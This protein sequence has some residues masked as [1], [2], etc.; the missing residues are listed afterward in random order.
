MMH[1]NS[2]GGDKGLFGISFLHS[3]LSA[4]YELKV[5][6]RV[7]LANKGIEG[8]VGQPATAICATREW[9]AQVG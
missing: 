8:F 1:E 5:E 7:T 3:A 4:E 9:P 2:A 6:E